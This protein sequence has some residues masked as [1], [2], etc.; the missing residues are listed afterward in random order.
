[1]L[2]PPSRAMAIGGVKNSLRIVSAAIAS[3]LPFV[4]RR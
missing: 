4:Y 3:P 1:V 2:L